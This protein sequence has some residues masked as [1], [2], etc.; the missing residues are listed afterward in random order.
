MIEIIT[1]SRKRTILS[2]LLV[3]SFILIP[4]LHSCEEDVPFTTYIDG[5]VVNPKSEFVIITDYLDVRD[6]LLLDENGNFEIT[7]ENLEAGLFSIA[8]PGEYQSFYLT[9]GDSVGLR[10]NTKA[11]DETLAFTGSH[12]R[13]NNFLIQL[14]IDI[15]KSNMRLLKFK[16][17]SPE[18]FYKN[19]LRVKE[20]RL[21][22]LDKAIAKYEFG[23]HFSKL[24][25]FIISLNSYYELE[26]YPILN[27]GNPYEDENVIFP[28]EFFAHR[29]RLDLNQAK[30]LNNYAFRPFMNALVSNIAFKKLSV[31]NID[32]VDLNSYYYNKERLDI[33]DSTLTNETLKNYFAASEIRNFIRRRKNATDINALVTDFLSMSTDEKINEEIAQLA[34][35][36]ISLDPGNPLPNFELRD[37]NNE[38][39]MLE[40]K[41]KRLSVL[42]YWSIQDKNYALG[43]HD[44]VKD[45]QLKYPEIEFIG[46]NIDDMD[47]DAWQ[48]VIAQYD[49]RDSREFQ[50]YGRS[51]IERELALR[52]SNRSMVV[53]RNLIIIDPNINLFYY[54]IE[55]TLLGY[56]NR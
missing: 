45:L 51:S 20:E 24:A 22:N 34:S 25:K 40:D 16:N 50:I 21:E 35:T 15:E 4:F 39:V 6:T 44:Q 42:Y 10:A 9:P 31:K 32:E 14:Y 26:R 38:T 37:I 8:Y 53:D 18:V 13:E 55:T 12:S 17:E 5:K 19:V 11:F 46:I 7:Y 28:E 47:Y 43:V 41:V 48:D 1:L 27:D 33:I 23:E 36:Y 54:R 3:L 2:R 29:S 56:L 52:N 49:F 30:L